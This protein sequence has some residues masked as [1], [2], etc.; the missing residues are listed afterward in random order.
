MIP[1]KGQPGKW[2]LI[3]DLSFPTQHSVN[4]G[5]PKD[6]FSLQ[7]IS[8]DDAIKILMVLGPRAL[9]AKFDVESAYRNVA[10]RP[11]ER[12][13]FGMRWR[14]LFF[15]DLALP[16]NLRSAPLIFNSIADM[17]EWILKVNYSVRY[18]LHYLDDFLS[19]GPAGSS[20]CAD[21]ITIARSVFSRL[22]LPLHPSKCEGPTPVLIFLGIELISPIQTA[23]LLHDKLI[24]TLELLYQWASKKWCTRTELKSLIGSLHHVT[25]VVPP[26]R[27]AIWP[28][29]WSFY[30]LGMGSVSFAYRRFV[31]FPIYLSLWIPLEATVLVQFGATRGWRNLGQR[32]CRPPISRLW[33]Y[34]PS[35]SR[36]TFGGVNG[37]AYKLSSF[38]TTM[39]S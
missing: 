13:L 7:Y 22:G 24:S 15:I 36:R 34:F 19:L 23:R 18:L 14:D 5:I 39:P 31:P 30:N 17:V 27:T 26:G 21:S 28:G 20:A 3:L 16:F 12:Y 2:R 37:H 11:D 6:P 32:R 10:M 33:S 4:D 25:K 29:G 35:W 38:A 8:V 9:M 1:K